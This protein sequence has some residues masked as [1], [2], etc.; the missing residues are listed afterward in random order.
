MA[1]RNC[2]E[3]QG[4]GRQPG[5]ENIEALGIC[6]ATLPNEFAGVNQGEQGGRFCWAVVGT[7]CLGRVQGTFAMKLLSCLRCEFLQQVQDEQSQSF[8]LTPGAAS[9]VLRRKA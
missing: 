6:P 1:R 9:E 4:C 8:I 5:G 2:W 7:L 3:A